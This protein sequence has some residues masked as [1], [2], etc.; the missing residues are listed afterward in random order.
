[1][2]FVANGALHIVARSESFSGSSYT[3]ARLKSQG[4]FSFTYGRVEWRAQMPYGVGLWPALWMLGTNIST[5]GIGWP[6]CGEVDVLE[7]KG[8][9]ITQVQSSIH[10]GSDGT[11]T[12]NF[13]DGQSITNGYHTYTF[14]WTP[15]TMLFYVDGHLF[16]TQNS[17]WGNSD[18]ASPFPFNKPFF[19][20]MNMAIGGNYVGNP[21]Q[22]DINT[23]TVFPAEVLVDY[24]RVY[25]TTPPL[26]I[27]VTQTNSSIILSWP[28][29][30]VCHLQAQTNPPA[31]GIGNN[32]FPVG[33]TTNQVQIIPITGSAF[34]RLVTP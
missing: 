26:L 13:T 18:G 34:F 11:T 16:E 21:S 27:S 30:I 33:T 17:P 4:L 14:D 7:N 25:N 8:T 31:T 5:S 23:G 1:N 9:N 32:W 10:Y 19:L 28:S 6:D 22:A 29:N 3:S 24:V 15:N 20:L 12:Y 2:A